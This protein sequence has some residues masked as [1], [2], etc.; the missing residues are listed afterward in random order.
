MQ[1][2]SLRF[3]ESVRI[4]SGVARQRGLTVPAFRS[5]PSDPTCDRSI[6][7]R[8]GG[9]VVAVRLSGRPFTAVQADLIDGIIAVNE[10]S[11]GE[12]V[13]VRRE[14]WAALARSGQVDDEG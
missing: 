5:P 12:Q 4:L 9:A 11:R 7:R 8:W 13:E 10:V 14:M 1:S 3:A 6:R 2:S